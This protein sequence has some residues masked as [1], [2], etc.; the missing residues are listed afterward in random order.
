MRV[1]ENPD[2]ESPDAEDPELFKAWGYIP[3]LGDRVLCV[4]YNET[5]APAANCYCL[6][7]PRSLGQMMKIDFDP[8]VDAAYLQLDDTKILNSE[9]VV[10][11]VIFDFNEQ[12]G[13]VGVEILGVRKKNPSHLLNLKIPFLCPDDR[14]A[15][16]S[17][18]MERAQV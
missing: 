11:G 3:E 6:L 7:R 17:F 5:S 4:V 9:E 10:P 1:L 18:L 8:E 15:F 2:H 13:V 12:G 16:E 14:K